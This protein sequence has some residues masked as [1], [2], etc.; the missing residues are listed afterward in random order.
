MA[1]T[2]CRVPCRGPF[3]HQEAR[4]DLHGF[5]KATIWELGE[6]RGRKGRKQEAKQCP[7]AC[8][9]GVHRKKKAVNRRRRKKNDYHVSLRLSDRR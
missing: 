1:N 3:R 6:V 5:W 2:Q 4:V 7:G 9:L 8:D